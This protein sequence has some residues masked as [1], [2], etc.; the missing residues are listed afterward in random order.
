[1]WHSG[2]VGRG[3]LLG[4]QLH[5]A[6]CACATKAMVLV[7]VGMIQGWAADHQD[8][9][10]TPPLLS[11][12]RRMEAGGAAGAAPPAGGDAAA[13]VQRRGPVAQ[14]NRS[15]Q[16]M[17]K[18]CKSYHHVAYKMFSNS[19]LRSLWI[20]LDTVTA[21]QRLAHG[22][23]LVMQDTRLGCSDWE[24]QQAEET[25]A[26]MLADVVGA[27]SDTDA[28]KD[29]QLLTHNSHSQPF[30]LPAEVQSEIAAHIFSYAMHLINLEILWLRRYSHQPAG[31]FASLI[32][33]S[34]RQ[35]ALE[36]LK[37]WTEVLLE[38]EAAAQTGEYPILQNA[39][40][41]MA[42]T[43]ATWVREI[44][45][46]LLETSFSEVPTDVLHELRSAATCF[47]S[48]VLAERSFKYARD[49]VRHVK[50]KYVSSK[51]TYHTLIS[52]PLN[53]EC[54][55]P[56]NYVAPVCESAATREGD[57]QDLYIASRHQDQRM[58]WRGRG[59]QKFAVFFMFGTPHPGTLNTKL[60]ILNKN[61]RGLIMLNGRRLYLYSIDNIPD[62][63]MCMPHLTYS[64]R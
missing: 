25:W 28:L 17:M 43:K 45:I 49:R 2:F 9:D 58:L 61:L 34:S 33:D 47:K 62:L 55:R 48:S 39:L 27:L 10:V 40:E 19:A 50:S 37:I 6:C 64:Q 24:W 41:S 35:R 31:R 44:L 16:A 8:D 7:Y 11:T 60:V 52:S 56:D 30:I 29:A 12:V 26:V 21:P 3:R 18:K 14:S 42:W 22:E 63:A 57:D 54:D 1:M 32:H 23:A 59:W 13:A 36:V 38:A 4:P 51:R 46:A 53:A 20:M 15:M 5:N